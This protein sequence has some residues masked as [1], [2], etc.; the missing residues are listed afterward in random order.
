VLL[1][2]RLRLMLLVLALV[3]LK[4]I[5]GGELVRGCGAWVVEHK[6]GHRYAVL[7]ANRALPSI[8]LPHTGACIPRAHQH[9]TLHLQAR[10]QAS[11]NNLV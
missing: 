3:L 4:P 1:L 11:L 5:F 10:T 8:K 9:I 7:L 2:L 6:A